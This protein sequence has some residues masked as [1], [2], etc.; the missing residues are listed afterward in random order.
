[1]LFK[2]L[3]W[4]ALPG[5]A[6]VCA[7]EAAAQTSYVA[8]WAMPERVYF[9]DSDSEKG[10]PPLVSIRTVVAI[11]PPLARGVA[12]REMTVSVDCAADTFTISGLVSLDGSL[13]PISRDDDPTTPAKVGGPYIGIRD[14]LCDGKIPSPTVRY[15][16]KPEAI[17]RGW[18]IIAA[19]RQ[20]AAGE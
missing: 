8:V 6:L 10:S 17:T 3:G 7:G 12:A 2:V 19:N 1:M 13:N 18:Q 15:A 9:V 4:A 14:Y 20:P 16:T 11:D 5:L